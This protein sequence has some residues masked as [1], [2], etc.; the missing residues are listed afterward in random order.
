MELVRLNTFEHLHGDAQQCS[1]GFLRG[2]YLGRRAAINAN[3]YPTA[4]RTAII[5]YVDESEW[6]ISSRRKV[7]DRRLKVFEPEGKIE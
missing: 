6:G 1:L 3:P 5:G 2:R 4:K 7:V